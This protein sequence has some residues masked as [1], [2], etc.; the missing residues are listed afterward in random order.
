MGVDPDNESSDEDSDEDET[1]IPPPIDEGVVPAL[2]WWDEAF[3]PKT[4]RENR[5]VSRAAAE[6]DDFA[7]LQLQYGKS[8]KYIQHPVAVKALG[9]YYDLSIITY[10]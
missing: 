10:E 8:Y 5:K 4:V 6:V 1:D 9:K 3:L 7:Q 2:E